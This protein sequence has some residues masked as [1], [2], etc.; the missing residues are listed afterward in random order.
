MQVKAIFDTTGASL[1]EIVAVQRLLDV[2]EL[3]V[4]FVHKNGL[5][6]D[7]FKR[8]DSLVHRTESDR[9]QGVINLEHFPEDDGL[10]IGLM[11]ENGYYFKSIHA[12]EPDHENTLNLIGTVMM[13]HSILI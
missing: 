3:L 7:E 5:S 4:K 9:L 1:Y 10:I 6:D 11:K 12:E 8:V 13:I 2:H